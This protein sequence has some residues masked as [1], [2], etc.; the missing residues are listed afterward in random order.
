MWHTPFVNAF[1]H[2]QFDFVNDSSLRVKYKDVPRSILPKNSEVILKGTSAF[3]RWNRCAVV[4][5][6]RLAV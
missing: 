4:G 2:Q 3:T 5:R 6:C 1:V